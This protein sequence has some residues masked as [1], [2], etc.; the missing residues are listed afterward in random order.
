MEKSTVMSNEI[1]AGENGQKAG[2]FARPVGRILAREISPKEI[3]AVSGGGQTGCLMYQPP[4]GDS[5]K[6][7]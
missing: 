2:T 6:Q 5:D 3:E 7:F 4:S 1:V